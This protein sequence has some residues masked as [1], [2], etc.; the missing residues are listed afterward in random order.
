MADSV[1]PQPNGRR[2]Q[3][4]PLGAPR[5]WQR[6]RHHAVGLCD[7]FNPDLYFRLVLLP[8]YGK[9]FCRYDLIKSMS[10]RGVSDSERR[11]NL[12]LTSERPFI[13]IHNVTG[14]CFVALRA[15]RNDI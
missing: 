9:N 1:L 12:Q 11:S 8:Q 2:R 13:G 14:D 4:I 5:R 7:N 15:T 6:T 10:L 3:R